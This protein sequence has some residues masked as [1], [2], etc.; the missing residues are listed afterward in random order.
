M[1]FTDFKYQTD[2]SDIFRVKLSAELGAL[3][4]AEPVG[5]RSSDQRVA[6]TGSRR[7]RTGIRARGARYSRNSGTAENPTIR[8]IFVTFLT[9][10]AYD[11]A[12]E[13]VTYKGN[14]W[15]RQSRY[16]EDY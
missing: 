4:G 7:R 5:A 11:A 14:T 12:P 6:V 13:T 2:D 15:T 1:A 3:G 9:E 8:T 16:A 10:T